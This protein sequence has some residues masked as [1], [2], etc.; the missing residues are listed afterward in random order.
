MRWSQFYLHTTREVPSDAEVVSHQ[1]MVRTG[2]LRKHAAGIYTYQ[3]LAWRSLLKLTE[4]VRRELNRSHAVELCMPFV[5]PAELWEE[6]GRWE[7]FGASL[8]KLQDRGGRDFC[9]GSDS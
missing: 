6:S 3:P 7:K 8:A 1:L 5:Q 4:I 2:M 9:L